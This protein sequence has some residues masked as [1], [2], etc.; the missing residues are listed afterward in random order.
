MNGGVKLEQE[1]W[2]DCKI[3]MSISSHGRAHQVAG[4]VN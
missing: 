2:F 4:Q 3:M 1:L